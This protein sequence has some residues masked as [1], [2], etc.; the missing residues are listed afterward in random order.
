[1][2]S[3][4]TLYR[5]SCCTLLALLP[6]SSFAQTDAFTPGFSG[7][8]SI[9]AG[10]SQNQSQSSTH[11]DN[12]S[13]ASLDDEGERIAQA[14]PFIL[15]RLQYSFGNTLIYLGNSDDQITQA[16]FQAELGVSQKITKHLVATGALFGNL[17]GMDEVW[18]DPYLTNQDRETTDQRVSGGRLSLD[19]NAPFPVS[20]KYAYATSDIEQDDIGLSLSLSPVQRDQL[21]RDSQYHRFGTELTF[22]LHPS[23][24]LAPALYY[25][26]RD[27][28]GDAHDFE[29][30]S[31]QLSVILNLHQHSI[32]TTI[33]NSSSAFDK[34]NP[35]FNQK[36]DQNTV[37]VFS[38]YSYQQLFGWQ[39]TQL[40]VM[41]GYQKQDSDI[42]FYDSENTFLSTGI[43]YNF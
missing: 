36:Q 19:F 20:V 43:S 18:E 7:T 17:P 40:H 8:L 4:F 1:M 10:W 30:F 28:K 24:I 37:G 35:V 32:T 11:D 34:E 31:A 12:A 33:R 27:T 38:V 22:P 39:G 13:T 41:A 9:N 5:W 42:N 21:A 2:I 15:G 29:Q 6:M 26:V 16:Q 14:A 3:R 25:T 23:V